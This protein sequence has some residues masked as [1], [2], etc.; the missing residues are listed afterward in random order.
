MVG[1]GTD[2]TRELTTSISR[3]EAANDGLSLSAAHLNFLGQAL[4]RLAHELKNHL[5]TIN[6]TAGLMLD[7]LKM[8]KRQRWG[9]AGRLFRR[10]RSLS[11]D[12]APFLTPLNTIQEEIVQAAA[13]IQQLGRFAHRMAEARPIFEGN[14]A[15]EEV[16]GLLLEKAGEK[17]I[18]LV[19]RLCKRTS[20]IEIDPIGF[21]MAVLFNVEKVMAGLEGGRRVVLESDV[22]EGIFQVCLSSPCPEYSPRFGSK[23]LDD[24][25]FYRD[26]LEELGGRILEQ[27]QDDKYSITLNFPL[28]RRKE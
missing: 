28:A 26:M 2:R 22:R 19:M 1:N 21:Q 13:L 18:H 23:E 9:W 12:M 27:S 8:K 16:Q 4:V 17:D 11:L 15:L 6:E 7:L 14:E 20:M 10:R 5:A 25:S 3:A 24:E